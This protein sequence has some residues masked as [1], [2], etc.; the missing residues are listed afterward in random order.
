MELVIPLIALGGLYIASNQNKKRDG[1]RSRGNDLPNTDIPDKNFPSDD[2]SDFEKDRTT[3][4]SVNN[5][6]DS[7]SVYTDKYFN[8]AKESKFIGIHSNPDKSNSTGEF[9]SLSGKS[10]D[11]NYFQHNN[12]TPY[13]GSK[14]HELPSVNAMESTLDNYSGS[15]SQSFEKREQAPMFAPDGNMQWANGTPNNTEFIRSRINPSQNMAGV[16]P[17]E[18]VRVGPGLGLGGGTE[19]QGGFNAGML[20]RELW[21][22][23]TVDELRT[24]SKQ[25][26][27]GLGMLGYEGPA[28]S[29]VQNRGDIGIM[30][31]NRV[32]TSFEMGADRLFT[33]TGIHKKPAMASTHIDRYVN[34]PDTTVEYAGAA[35]SSNPA[36]YVKGEY[37]QTHN[38]ELGEYPLQS[39][40]AGG[41]GGAR[42]TDYGAKSNTVYNN[43][44]SANTD[45]QYY[46]SIGGAIGAAIAPLMDILRPSRKENTVGTLRPYQNAKG[47]EKSYVYNPADRPAHTIRETTE[48]GKYHPNINANQNGGAY[49]ITGAH[50]DPTHRDSTSVSYTGGASAGERGRQARTYNAEYNQ[51]TNGIKSSVIK[52]YTPSGGMSLLNADIAITAKPKDEHLTNRR[53]VISNRGSGSS[54]IPSIETMGRIGGNNHELYQGSQLDRN[55]GSVMSQLKGNPYNISS[56]SGI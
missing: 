10:V 50:F 24:T 36:H 39:A 44:R 53:A 46:G 8:S 51:S 15:G 45:E 16:K 2:I 26:A 42:E 33:T 6:F 35:G 1:F 56:F 54:T 3:E 19:G 22:D 23:K 11:L 20:G 48:V 40:Y 9:T 17:F 38:I 25:K 43:N 28:G 27:T 5:V 14:S 32:D 41:K 4:L 12:M 37:M 31:K 13:F 47:A 49:E 55:N 34:R 30:E 18:D 7:P 52:G 29:H 21:G